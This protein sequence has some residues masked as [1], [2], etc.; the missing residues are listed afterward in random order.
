MVVQL[1]GPLLAGSASQS[2]A[3]HCGQ[4]CFRLGTPNPLQLSLSELYGFF[5]TA[6][7]G[8]WKVEK[9]PSRSWVKSRGNWVYLMLAWNKRSTFWR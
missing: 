2:S 4:G 1:P 6:Q 3:S 7:G 8:V 9:K 5:T